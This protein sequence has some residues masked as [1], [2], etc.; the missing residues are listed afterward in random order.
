MSS[1]LSRFAQTLV[2]DC[3]VKIPTSTTTAAGDQL[4]FPAAHAQ[5]YRLNLT[6]FE[7]QPQT[8]D[9]AQYFSS[10]KSLAAL[11][12]AYQQACRVKALEQDSPTAMANVHSYARVFHQHIVTSAA[13][14]CTDQDAV[15]I[16]DFVKNLDIYTA[17]KA[18]ESLL[19]SPADLRFLSVCNSQGWDVH[20]DHIAI[21]CGR[22]DR[23][24]AE[25]I[26]A[27][28]VQ[29][30]AYTASQ[31]FAERFY[32]FP[33]GWNAYPLYKILDNGQVL[34]IFVDQSDGIE[35]TQI[36]QHWNYVYGYTAHHLALRASR[37]VEGARVAVPLQEIMAALAQQNITCLTPTGE[38]SQGLLVQVF[39]KPE[40]NHAIP[41]DILKQ[42]RDI[43]VS[44][45]EKIHNAKL[46]EIV[47]RR[48]G[49]S[50]LALDYFGLYDI[51][52]E[53]QNPLHSFPLYQYFLPGQAA[54]V[55]Q[56]SV[57]V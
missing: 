32:A 54:H 28:L 40:L 35:A 5:Q 39:A 36:I 6:P 19:Y 12:G 51:R 31:I 53:V 50:A 42:L 15:L 16:A 37:L 22:A 30:H 49:G 29:Q 4:I 45:G 26:V 17:V 38:Y 46:L 43:D 47:S 55:I 57:Q 14:K 24:D 23:Q 33:E 10:V 18:V 11:I 48:E 13:Q 52:Y 25:R 9:A 1:A 3:L 20:F 21:R 2:A 56:T 7:A 34:R 27:L 41:E 8:A 44:L